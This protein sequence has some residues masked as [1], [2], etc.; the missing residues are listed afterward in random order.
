MSIQIYLMFPDSTIAENDKPNGTKMDCV[1]FSRKLIKNDFHQKAFSFKFDE[2]TGCQTKKQFDGFV[3]YWSNSCNKVV[4]VYCG[5]LF[6]DNCPTEKLVNIF[7]S[8]LKR[9]V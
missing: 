1:S 3:Q 4:L 5:S 9:L 7:I 8:S 6:V 2:T